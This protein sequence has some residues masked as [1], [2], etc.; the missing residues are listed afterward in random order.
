MACCCGWV[1]EILVRPLHR[2]RLRGLLQAT[3]GVEGLSRKRV[4]ESGLVSLLLRLWPLRT[5]E[6]LHWPALPTTP[7]SDPRTSF[8]PLSLKSQAGHSAF[9]LLGLPS[10]HAGVH[11]ALALPVGAGE[12]SLQ[13]TLAPAPFERMSLMCISTN[14]IQVCPKLRHQPQCP[15]QTKSG[16]AFVSGKH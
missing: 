7:C 1:G 5:S 14:F 6:L 16:H 4:L 10:L 13:S 15:H 8:L 2:H 12:S 11:A 3:S 9:Y